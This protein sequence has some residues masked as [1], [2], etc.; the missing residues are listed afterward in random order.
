MR[1]VGRSAAVLLITAA[2]WAVW[3]QGGEV[4][5]WAGLDALDV[6]GRLVLVFAFLTGC[7]A[8]LGWWK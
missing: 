8:V 3:E 2:S 6:V 1:P 5:A 4:L 7:E